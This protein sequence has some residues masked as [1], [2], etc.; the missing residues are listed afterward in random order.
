VELKADESSVKLLLVGVGERH[1]LH[2]AGEHRLQFLPADSRR[3]IVNLQ[4]VA[5]HSWWWAVGTSVGRRWSAM[6]T[7]STGHFHDHSS[8]SQVAAIEIVHGVLGVSVIVE[9]LPRRQS[10]S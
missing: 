2:F 7:T 9:L 6:E 4:T 8:S 3:K 1:S 10:R 5:R